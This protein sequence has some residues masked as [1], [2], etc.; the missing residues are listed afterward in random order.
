MNK[1]HVS[2]RQ[3]EV[4]QAFPPVW[5]A[6][7]PHVE[8]CDS[9]CQKAL[10]RGTDRTIETERE[11]M[12]AGDFGLGQVEKAVAEITGRSENFIAQQHLY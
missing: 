6:S 10:A 8:T 11:T 2:N 7:Y 3:C 1:R 5:R 4:C 12:R 9:V